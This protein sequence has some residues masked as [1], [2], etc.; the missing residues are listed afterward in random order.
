MMTSTDADTSTD[1][2]SRPGLSSATI[3]PAST[4]TRAMIG[5]LATSGIVSPV[6]K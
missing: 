6:R 3:G 4:M 1:R 2:G 5:T